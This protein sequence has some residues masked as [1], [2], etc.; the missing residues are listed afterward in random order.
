MGTKTQLLNGVLCCLGA[1]IDAVPVVKILEVDMP[2]K[3][4]R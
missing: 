3:S 4:C 2:W 1:F